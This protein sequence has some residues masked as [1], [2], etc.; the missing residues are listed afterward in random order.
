MKYHIDFDIDFRRNPYKGLYIAIEGIDGSGKT[1]QAEKIANYFEQK[2][3]AVVLTG[4]PR[5]RDSIISRLIQEILTLKIKIPPIAL[6]YLFSAD[7]AIHQEE[8]IVPSL[9]QGKIVVSDRCLWSAVPYGIMDKI[10][11]GKIKKYDYKETEV[12]LAAHGILSMYHQFIIPDF[13]FYLDVPIETAIKRI[14]KK[15]RIKELYEQEEKLGNVID[16]Y[17]WLAKTFPKEIIRID[18]DGEI[19]QVTSAILSEIKNKI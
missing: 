16:G 9:R 11:S 8:V 3:K 7:R 17:R 5:K 13:A 1:T 12:L 10:M 4:E 6:Q 18:G 2:G 19:E 15:H 14:N